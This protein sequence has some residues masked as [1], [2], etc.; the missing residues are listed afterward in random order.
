MESEGPP[1]Q[2]FPYQAQW[3]EDCVS[4]ALES[5]G[6]PRRPRP[7]SSTIGSIPRSS[8][9]AENQQV[10]ANIERLDDTEKLDENKVLNG[11]EGNNYEFCPLE[12]ECQLCWGLKGWYIG[13]DLQ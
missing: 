1:P 3:Y 7:P 4:I 11:Y 12:P 8:T 10:S 6:N 9:L 2:D 5:V 13:S